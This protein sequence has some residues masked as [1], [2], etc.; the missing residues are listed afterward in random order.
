MKGSKT[1]H[2]LSIIR[3]L[4]QNKTVC[5][6]ELASAL[7]ISIRTA[8]RY[9]ADISEFFGKES[10]LLQSRGCYKAKSPAL[11]EKVLIRPN[12]SFIVDIF[13]DF[14]ADKL[15]GERLS[16]KSKGYIK[17]ELDK[18]K[19]VFNIKNDPFSAISYRVLN[20][21]KEAI[22]DRRMVTIS[23]SSRFQNFEYIKPI[24][25]IFEECDFYLAFL[26]QDFSVNKS[27]RYVKIS[28]I[29]SVELLPEEFSLPKE[30]VENIN[31]L[32]VNRLLLS[33]DFVVKIAI[34][35][36]LMGYFKSEKPLYMQKVLGVNDQGWLEVEFSSNNPNEVY[37]LAKKHLP[38][39]KI[40]SPQTLKSSFLKQIRDFI[41]SF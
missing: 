23:L 39:I 14:F 38:H 41:D 18:N 30:V 36:P 35:P 40:V 29:S 3:D 4:S 6:K 15:L 10:I 33:E 5:P 31:S 17:R 21:L 1:F 2:I 16:P 37:G 26:M 7:T 20:D 12:K 11:F 34:A 32:S 24:R 27:V 8:Q 19:K 9:I 22:T 13:I 28:Q 25:I